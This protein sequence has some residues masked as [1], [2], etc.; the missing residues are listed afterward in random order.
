MSELSAQPSTRRIALFYPWRPGN[1][2]D[3]LRGIFRFAR[4]SQPWEFCLTFDHD[5]ARLL[6]WRPVGIIGHFFSPAAMATIRRP[7]VPA[8]NTALDVAGGGV[9]QVGLDDRTV[10]TLAA[11]YLMDRGFRE[12]AFVGDEK[13]KFSRR[14]ADGFTTRL[15]AAGRRVLHAP[16]G[17]FQAD[18]EALR[19]PSAEAQRWLRALPTPVGAFAA[20]DHLARQIIETARAAGCAAAQLLARL[21]DGDAPPTTRLESPPLGV[22]TRQ[23]TDVLAVTDAV[24]AGTTISRGPRPRPGRGDPTRATRACAS[25]AD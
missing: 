13:K 23:S 24:L 8:V 3:S 6:A 15:R 10:G 7:R 12:L 20:G 17:L 22:V 1:A 16:G 5:L 11:E 14:T 4:P 21:L 9:P 19:P 2:Q 25:T 18:A